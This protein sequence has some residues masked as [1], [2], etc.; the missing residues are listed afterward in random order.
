[1]SLLGTLLAGKM[2]FDIASPLIQKAVNI[3]G[4]G[5][6]AT[7]KL[8]IDDLMKAARY[9]E[10]LKGDPEEEGLSAAKQMREEAIAGSNA[11]IVPSSED[12]KENKKPT[13]EAGG[14]GG[15]E[16]PKK[17]PKTIFKDPIDNNLDRLEPP[18]GRELQKAAVESK[19]GE[20]TPELEQYAEQLKKEQKL[21]SAV[22][23]SKKGESLGEELGDE[24]IDAEVA[25]DVHWR[26]GNAFDESDSIDVTPA[27]SGKGG[28]KKKPSSSSGA[29]ALVIPSGSKKTPPS[30]GGGVPPSSGG[31]MAKPPRDKMSNVGKLAIASDIGLNVFNLLAGLASGAAR[32]GGVGD[33]TPFGIKGVDQIAS[34]I[35]NTSGDVRD[36]VMGGIFRG[37]VQ[38][39]R[40][41]YEIDK[42]ELAR[43]FHLPVGS[44]K[45][46]DEV[47]YRT[48]LGQIQDDFMFDVNKIRSSL[49]L[50]ERRAASLGAS[51][52]A[53]ASVARSP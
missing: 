9:A 51:T 6:N 29:G 46:I 2:A 42:K 38:Q 33:Q 44:P 39:R 43:L 4:V 27:T 41:Q 1:M 28:G 32:I 12:Q 17:P 36:A 3:G 26:E 31:T 19:A 47:S 48:M 25:D 49:N 37:Y 11:P 50:R 7:D 40:E 22:K 10:S 35:S 20:S 23:G 18:S 16:P 52:S 14:G 21:L 13:T 24:A 8:D 15:K 34:A 30:S 53:G 45:K 5:E